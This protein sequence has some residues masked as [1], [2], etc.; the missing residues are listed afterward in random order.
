MS[1]TWF[2]NAMIS[3]CSDDTLHI[4]VDN[5]AKVHNLI[6]PTYIATWISDK[7]LWF[8]VMYCTQ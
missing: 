1:G 2:G 6:L 3:A 5:K 8:A 4:H 7:A